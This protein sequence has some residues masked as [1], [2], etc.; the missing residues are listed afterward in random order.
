MSRKHVLAAALATFAMVATAS[1]ETITSDFLHP[2]YDPQHVQYAASKGQFPVVVIDSPV[3]VDA[4]LQTLSLP[5]SYP[6]SPLTAVSPQSHRGGYLVLAFHAPRTS[7]G[8]QA[9]ADP[10]A[11]ATGGSGSLRLQAAFC[12]GTAVLS[13]A[14]MTAPAPASADDPAFA[15]AM[16]R[17]FSQVLS[18]KS[19][20]DDGS[21]GRP[22]C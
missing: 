15:S 22:N 5:G 1:A 10:A 8:H 3:P 19:P 11:L 12:S 6:Q 16:A 17:L 9:C 7:N 21:C 13:E 4:M 20:N 18:T 14:I 2:S